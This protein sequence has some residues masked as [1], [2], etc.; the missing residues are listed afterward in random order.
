MALFS[1]ATDL[2]TN[3]TVWVTT[4]VVKGL[5]QLNSHRGDTI[6][7]GMESD[8]L[9]AAELANLYTPFVGWQGPGHQHCCNPEAKRLSWNG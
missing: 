7:R 1:Q 5:P 3:Q 4:N 6:G 8:G 2:A 9:P